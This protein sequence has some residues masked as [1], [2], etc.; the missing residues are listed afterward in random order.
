MNRET[1][2]FLHRKERTLFLTIREGNVLWT[3]EGRILF[4]TY[5]TQMSES[6]G[7][8]HVTCL[9]QESRGGRREEK[10]E[11]KRQIEMSSLETVILER[12]IFMC[13]FIRSF[14]LQDKNYSR[15][16]SNLFPIHEVECKI[17][18]SSLWFIPSKQEESLGPK[19]TS[20]SSEA[21]AVSLKEK[22]E[23]ERD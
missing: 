17:Q 11:K 9:C 1:E 2:V 10:Q 18:L 7:S 8:S 19:S 22:W 3:D 6:S 12:N 23:D 20:G 16:Q 15:L 5:T 14:R 4:L 21:V 13:S